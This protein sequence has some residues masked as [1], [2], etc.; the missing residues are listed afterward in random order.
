MLR[1]YGYNCNEMDH[2]KWPLD[3]S[4]PDVN[5]ISLKD[6]SI[7]MIVV[8]IVKVGVY[9]RNCSIT[10]WIQYLSLEI[11]LECVTAMELPPWGI[12]MLMYSYNVET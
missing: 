1:L 11:A 10:Q 9:D 6:K 5:S 8:Q 4:P 7:I 3:L 12:N 2:G